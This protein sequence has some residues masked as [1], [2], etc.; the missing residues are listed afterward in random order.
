[1]AKFGLP[2]NVC[3]CMDLKKG[4]KVI[5]VIC[6]ITSLLTIFLMGYYLV[7]DSDEIVKEIADGSPDTFENI[8][9]HN[10]T[11]ETIVVVV[12][13]LSAVYFVTSIALVK[14]VDDHNRKL[15]VP[16]LVVDAILCL[17]M[18]G[19]ACFQYGRSEVFTCLTFMMIFF[20]FYICIYA[21]YRYFD[22]QIIEQNNTEF[23]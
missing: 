11:V 15:L 2:D 10:A 16:F 6:I 23:N 7:S 1:M 8:K 14:G 18:L 4:G 12:L 9:E 19:F 21:L 13:V 22:E 5:G 17:T 3:C 20:Y